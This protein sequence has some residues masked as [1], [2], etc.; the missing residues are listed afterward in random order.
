MR[1][2]KSVRK[3]RF[4]TGTGSTAFCTV[5]CMENTAEQPDGLEGI[6]VQITGNHELWLDLPV[7][8]LTLD[9]RQGLLLAALLGRA[10]E[11]VLELK[12]EPASPEEAYSAPESNA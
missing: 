7:G 11:K 10:V 8:G 3:T 4:Y 5:A 2:P 12:K 6:N 9:L 1:F